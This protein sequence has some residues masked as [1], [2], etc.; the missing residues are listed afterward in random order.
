MELRLTR[1][2]GGGKGP[3]LMWHGLGVSSDY[4]ALDTIEVSMV[5]FF[6]AQHY[7]VWLVD[8]RASIKLPAASSVQHNIDEVANYDFPAV[9]DKVLEVTGQVV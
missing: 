3:L 4:Y 2:D 8:W 5:E 9:V 6:V 7:D 1:Y